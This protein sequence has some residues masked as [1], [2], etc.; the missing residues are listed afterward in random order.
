[1]SL[2]KTNYGYA[3]RTSL[4]LKQA[5]K[6]SKV[7]KKKTEKLVIL[8]K[9]LCKSAKMVQEKIKLNYNKKDLRDQTLKRE[10]KCGYYTKTSE[11][12]N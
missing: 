10:I 2:F 1:M 3:L 8:H 11:V 7:G 9:E 12:N 4:S 5:R 6:S